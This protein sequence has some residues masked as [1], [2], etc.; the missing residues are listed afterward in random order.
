MRTFL[1]FRLDEFPELSDDSRPC[2]FASV[3]FE[4]NFSNIL[5]KQCYLKEA[6][7]YCVQRRK[8]LNAPCYHG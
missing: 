8:T 2:F 1:S 3:H 7:D 6:L 4:I 5:C